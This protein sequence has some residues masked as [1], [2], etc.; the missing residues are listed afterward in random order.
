[1]GRSKE[2]DLPDVYRV[3]PLI[4]VIFMIIGFLSSVK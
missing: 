4:I 3:V 2:R 1:M